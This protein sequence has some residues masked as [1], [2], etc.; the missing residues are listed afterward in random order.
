MF[1]PAHNLF[2]PRFLQVTQVVTGTLEGGEQS[3]GGLGLTDDPPGDVLGEMA[4][5]FL[6]FFFFSRVLL[7]L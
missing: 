6:N 4:D 5:I 7:G 2:V 3:E 1:L